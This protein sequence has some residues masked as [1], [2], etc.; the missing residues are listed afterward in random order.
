M[1]FNRKKR[2][3]NEEFESKTL[4]QRH[5]LNSSQSTHPDDLIF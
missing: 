5:P 2:A 1:S 4:E 3:S